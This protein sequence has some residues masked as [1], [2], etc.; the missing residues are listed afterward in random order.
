MKINHNYLKAFALSM[1]LVGMMLTATNLNAQNHSTSSWT[2]GLFERGETS[3][4]SNRD[5]G[6]ITIGNMQN[7]NPTPL[8]SGLLIMLGAGLGYAALKKKKE[9]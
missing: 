2:G 9:D 7:D 1:G 3:E 8:G 6:G 4:Y 5:S